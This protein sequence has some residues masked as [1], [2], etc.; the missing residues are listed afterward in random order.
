MARVYV[1]E[2]RKEGNRESKKG[3]VIRRGG[4]AG[5]RINRREEISEKKKKGG[6]GKR[7]RK[8]TSRVPR[9]SKPRQV[10]PEK[11]GLKA[12]RGKGRRE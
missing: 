3:L 11:T 7:E 1:V 5:W 12:Q 6:V 4:Q 8:G 10:I 2:L 9:I